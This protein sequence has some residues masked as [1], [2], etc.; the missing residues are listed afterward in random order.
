MARS[1]I[2]QTEP[3]RRRDYNA[4]ILYI[5][6][7]DYSRKINASCRRHAPSCVGIRLDFWQT[8]GVTSHNRFL[9]RVDDHVEQ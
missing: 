5:D 7:M 3:T 4:D 8:T 2:V 1:N 6:L 9:S